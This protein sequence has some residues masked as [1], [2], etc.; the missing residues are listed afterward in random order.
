MNSET[1][2]NRT[3][4]APGEAPKTPRK[5]GRFQANKKYF[6]ICIYAIIT[7]CVCLL[8]FKFTNNWQAT[9]A[10][11]AEVFSVMTP[12]LI[13]F[14][15]AYFINP[16]IRRIDRLLDRLLKGRLIGVH[17]LI[18]LIIAYIVVIGFIALVLTF[19]IP[20]IGAS[21]LELIRQA[22]SMYTGVED[23]LNNFIADHPNMN[24]EA[25][26]QFVNENLPN[27]FQYI[28]GVMTSLVPMIYNAGLSI[29]SWIINIILAFVISCYLMWDKANLLRG[30]KRIIYALFT[31]ETAEKIIA[32]IKK[33]N[34]IFSAF[35]IGKAIDSLI[36]GI[37]CFIL[38]CILGLPYAV[39][40][41]VIVGITNM[42]PYFG[43]F[44][45]AIPGAIVLLIIS[46]KQALIFVIMILILQQ[47]DG[48]ILGPK[49]LGDSTGLQPIW[50]IFAITVGG[51]L[52]GVVG[53]FLGVPV[54]AVI[55]YLLN[56]LVE[57]FLRKR[58]LPAE[59]GEMLEA[60][61]ETVP[62]KPKTSFKERVKSIKKKK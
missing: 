45:G 2:Q 36:I 51:Y 40:L 48:N 34:E 16:M 11:F 46:P 14:L 22:P 60:P 41:S 56:T 39:L 55:A 17:R 38:M 53:M 52:A 9:R 6:T 13:A 10:R 33:C 4:P 18:S 24:L 50:I 3:G 49:I 43:P 19:V 42:I 30:A 44:I 35:I 61:P 31:Q 12:F 23:G 57:F 5:N 29:I 32:I 26:Q 47:F 7:F 37:L 15:I 54:T 21:I 59:V 25:I 28:Q 8:I 27:M 20:Q 62:G 58:H 1:D